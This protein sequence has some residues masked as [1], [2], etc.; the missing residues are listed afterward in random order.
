MFKQPEFAVPWIALVV[1]VHFVF[2]G[3]AWEIG[4][5]NGLG[6]V[7]TALGL[8]GFALAATGAALSTVNRVAGVLS[9]VA[10]LATVV[11]GILQARPKQRVA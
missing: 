5:Y 9:G 7:Q 11:I 6:Y 8:A 10:L 1:G 4:L 3:R 2:L